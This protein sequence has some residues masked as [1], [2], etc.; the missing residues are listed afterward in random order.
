M[1][2]FDVYWIQETQ[3]ICLYTVDE[4]THM[5]DAAPASIR[6]MTVSNSTDRWSHLLYSYLYENSGAHSA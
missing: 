4:H 3:S 1:L 6:P 5:A 2:N